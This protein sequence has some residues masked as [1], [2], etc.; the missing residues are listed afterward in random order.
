M[1]HEFVVGQTYRRRDIHAKYGGQ[2]QGGISTPARVPFV[3]IFTGETGE[4]YGYR[5][6][7][8]SAGT[9]LYTGEGQLGDMRFISG[10][11]AIRD[12]KKNRKQLLLF[13]Q[14]KKGH[15]EFVGEMQYAGDQ[16]RRGPDK[17]GREREVI[18][19]E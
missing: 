7:W 6:D 10:N 8:T 9:Y 15:V 18:V 1:E 3:F 16:I 11:R 19:F 12:Q 2:R 17:N 13:K 14:I 4:Q 5:D